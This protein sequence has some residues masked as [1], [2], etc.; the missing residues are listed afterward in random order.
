MRHDLHRAPEIISAPFLG[1]H[2]VIDPAGGEVVLLTHIN[3]GIPL[4]VAEIEVS[5]RPV[6]TAP[7][8]LINSAGSTLI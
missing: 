6:V 5:L 8:Q 2:I 4:V 1:D 3:I 7:R